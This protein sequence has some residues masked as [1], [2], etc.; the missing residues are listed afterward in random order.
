MRNLINE[1]KL[2]KQQEDFLILAVTFLE[3]PS[4]IM[5]IADIAGKPLELAHKLLPEK[6]Q[7]VI[8]SAVTKSLNKA[9]EVAILSVPKTDQLKDLSWDETQ[10]KVQKRAWMHLAAT[11]TTGAIGGFFGIPGLAIELP[12]STTLILRSIS[13]IALNYGVDLDRTEN[14]LEC[15]YVLTLGTKGKYDDSMESSY[16]TSRAAFANSIRIAADFLAKYS[17]REVL[18][19]LEKGNAPAILQFISRVASY[20]EVAVTEKMLV[21]ALPIVGSIGGAA[22]NAAFTYFFN[23][24]AKFHFGLKKLESEHGESLISEE[25]KRALKIIELSKVTK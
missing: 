21:E 4:L 12:I 16:L 17:A 6:T 20:F 22:I 10:K 19:A 11:T 2:S 24:A 25:Y 14:R 5:K 15:L 18:K 8:Q 23:N 9:L 7:S 13:E 1:S 3:S